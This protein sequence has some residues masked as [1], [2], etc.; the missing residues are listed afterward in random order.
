MWYPH[1]EVSS[2]PFNF[3]RVG[4]ETSRNDMDEGD[5]TF[6]YT[7]LFDF[8]SKE[9]DFAFGRILFDGKRLAI[10]DWDA[11]RTQTSHVVAKDY[12]LLPYYNWGDC[13]LSII[14]RLVTRQEKYTKR[15]F[16]VVVEGLP[17]DVPG[18][19]ALNTQIILA[20]EIDPIWIWY[21]RFRRRDASAEMIADMEKAVKEGAHGTG[22]FVGSFISLNRF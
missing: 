1:V 4:C 22:A 17:E 6:N 13:G 10:Q 15:G 3:T 21:D 14:G 5:E 8:V 2:V 12:K 11:V 9:A 7:S 18:R 16:N 19:C 20:R